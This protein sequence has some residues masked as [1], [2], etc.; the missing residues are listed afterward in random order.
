[1]EGDRLAREAQEK[2]QSGVPLTVLFK[3]VEGE[4]WRPR[5][6]EEVG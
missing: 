6:E 2:G 5:S 4:S 1:M 3:E